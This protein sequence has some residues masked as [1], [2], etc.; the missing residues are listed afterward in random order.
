[1]V[2]D[3]DDVL[4]RSIARVL[5]LEGY[6]VIQADDA[7]HAFTALAEHPG[8]VG[9]LLCDL[10]LPGLSGREAASL[11]FARQPDIRVLYTSGYSSHGSARQQLLSAGEAFL[12]KPFEPSELV[13]AVD[14]LFMEQQPG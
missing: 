1:L 13:A 8:P 14:A 6:Q 10:V 11:I 3:D 12:A 7:H 9:V 2:L 4:R 5:E